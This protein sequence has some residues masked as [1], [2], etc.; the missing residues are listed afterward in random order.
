MHIRAQSV[1]ESFLLK[2][3]LQE[4]VREWRV[5]L[6][7][8][9]GVSFLKEY[10]FLS[11]VQFLIK[12]KSVKCTKG[13]EQ[14]RYQTNVELTLSTYKA[15]CLLT[16]WCR[17]KRKNF[18]NLVS[19]LFWEITFTI[20]TLQTISVFIVKSAH[21]LMTCTPVSSQPNFFNFISKRF[22]LSEIEIN[23]DAPRDFYDNQ[24]LSSV[25]LVCNLNGSSKC[26]GNE[27]YIYI[28]RFCSML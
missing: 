12:L 21:T 14:R 8:K 26:Y 9:N 4:I 6:Q 11:I 10:S 16:W 28:D 22:W 2:Y 27:N 3:W 15:T 17:Y 25:I 5:Y 18:W 1:H 7:Y 23:I 13:L 20:F 24:S 19:C